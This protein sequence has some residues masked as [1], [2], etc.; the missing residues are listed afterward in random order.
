MP[1]ADV[2]FDPTR[3][4]TVA[5]RIA[6]FYGS[7]P[8]GRIQTELVNR[9]PV[10]V[11][12]KALVFRGESDT[13]PS[14]TGW[15]TEREGDGDINT[16]AC[17]ENTETSA[18]GRALANLGFQAA[19]ERPSVE[20][21]KKATRARENRARGSDTRDNV[22]AVSEPFP[23]YRY[24]SADLGELLHEAEQV[25]LRAERA[26]RLRNE[27]ARGPMSP[28]RMGVVERSLRN[29]LYRHTDVTGSHPIL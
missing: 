8:N 20:E 13:V 17:L 11:T 2:F 9:D 25:G 27:L 16:V 14:A 15:A 18:I 23:E 28:E 24:A 12:F 19:K 6:L 22:V 1:K 29:W 10:S 3:Y 7:H 26:Q 21:M 4:A 5:E